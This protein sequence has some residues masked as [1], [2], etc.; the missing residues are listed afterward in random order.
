MSLCLW[1]FSAHRPTSLHDLTDALVSDL[2]Q[3]PAAMFQHLVESLPGRVDGG[4]FCG[5][6]GRTNPKIEWATYKRCDFQVST[7]LWPQSLS[8]LHGSTLLFSAV[9]AL[10]LI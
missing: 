6:K 9:D 4:S 10:S 3:I 2:D 1:Y 8:F 5:R 7:Y